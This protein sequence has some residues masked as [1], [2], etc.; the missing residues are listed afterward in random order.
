MTP[1]PPPP[2]PHTH[3]LSL[4]NLSW[5]P[6]ALKTF[7]TSRYFG[8]S[9]VSSGST[10]CSLN[11]PGRPLIDILHGIN[12]MGGTDGHRCC[13]ECEQDQPP[14]SARPSSRPRVAPLPAPT[15][16]HHRDHRVTAPT[17]KFPLWLFQTVRR[18]TRKRI[19]R[20]I[21]HLNYVKVNTNLH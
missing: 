4:P 5:T 9:H 15:R 1:F 6:R 11:F 8:S 14:R 17:I 10:E 21:T 18:G 19:Y 2:S 12:Q 3:M 16:A 7:E 13:S 20:L